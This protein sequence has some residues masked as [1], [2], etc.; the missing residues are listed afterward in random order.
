MM[1]GGQNSSYR[2]IRQPTGKKKLRTLLLPPKHT[3]SKML[4]QYLEKVRGI[5]RMV[6]TDFI[7]H[8]LIY[9]SHFTNDIG[10][11]HFNAVFLGLD[12]ECIPRQASIRG[13][14]TDYKADASG[15]DKRYSLSLAPSGA[16]SGVLHVFES[17][18]DLMSYLTLGGMG[19]AQTKHDHLIS[20]SGIYSPKRNADEQRMPLAIGRYVGEHPELSK[21]VLHLDNDAAGRL[22]AQA[23][24]LALSDMGIEST[25]APPP[26][27]KD[28]NDYLK[29]CQADKTSIEK[30]YRE[31]R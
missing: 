26:Y 4:Y 30:I 24:K 2:P 11:K 5:D 23:L 20:L 25:D 22:S 1:I 18:I 21:A 7:Q 14:F 13:I 31:A 9:E 19:K 10:M 17:A 29:R 8:G 15:S 12:K 28:Y 6:I 16:E 3:D 27:G